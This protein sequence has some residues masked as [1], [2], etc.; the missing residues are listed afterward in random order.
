MAIVARFQN[1]FLMEKNR[2]VTIIKK[3]TM[4]FE[5]L[6]TKVSF[7]KTAVSTTIVGLHYISH[8]KILARSRV[9]KI[10]NSA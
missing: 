6:L 4:H 3:A 7:S 1:V 2:Q 9:Y 10:I 8:D 5:T